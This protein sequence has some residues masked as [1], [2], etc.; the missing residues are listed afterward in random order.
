MYIFASIFA[1]LGLFFIGVRLIANNLKQLAGRRMRHLISRA[2]AVRGSV[3]LFGLAAG[4]IMQ[5]LNAVTHV[6]AALVAAG[7]IDKRRAFPVINWANNGTATLVVLASIDL[8]LAALILVGL[9]GLTYYL[10]LDQSAR[11]RHVVGALFGAGVLFLGI[12]F[13]KQGSTILKQEALHF[14]EKGSSVV[15]DDA[16]LRSVMI[17]A[18]DHPILGF[19]IGTLAAF[20]AQSSSTVTVVAMAMA[21]AGLLAFGSGSMIVIGAGL[22]SALSTMLIGAGLRGSTRQL[23]DY[24][25]VLKVLGVVCFLALWL[26]DALAGGGHA[27]AALARIGL[28]IGAQLATVFVLMQVSS[29]LSMRLVQGPLLAWI[30]RRSPP[31]EV[32]VL[33]RPHFLQDEALVEPES[34]LLLVELEQQRLLGSLPAYLEPLRD[35][36]AAP[37]GPS[38]PE[39][40]GAEHGVLRLSAQFI[41]EVI[42]QN[43]SRMVLE[44]SMVLRDRNELLGS[45][46]DSLL[47]FNV[48]AADPIAGDQ[49]RRIASPLV[50]SLHMMLQTLADFGREVDAADL[51]LFTL[52]THD[53]SEMMDTMRRRMQAAEHSGQV[54]QAVFSATALFERCVWLLRRY[55]LLLSPTAA[56]A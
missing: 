49:V 5:S 47:E 39:R 29:D 30:E 33:G 21:S 14:I 19:G 50:E 28:P 38:V 36:G 37:A 10:N 44:Q 32:E 46:Q 55:V 24:Q 12:D 26:I 13:I 48:L 43:N 41:S 18:L 23:V 11:Y 27:E 16:W 20:V 7:A 2:V 31:S 3:V 45:L 54:Q 34:A 52:L 22:G 6:L 8:H 40:H 4:A 1:G 42:D 9:I 51:E 53:R 15:R 35:D 17:A 56:A 25:V